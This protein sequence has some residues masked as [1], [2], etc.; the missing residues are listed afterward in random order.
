MVSPNAHCLHKGQ[1]AFKKVN[2]LC[3]CS[4]VAQLH[5][6]ALTLNYI[7][8]Q[9]QK[10][11]GSF[12]TYSHQMS[13]SLVGCAAAQLQAHQSI[14]ANIEWALSSTAF[15][16][17]VQLFMFANSINP[18]ST[19]EDTSSSSSSSSSGGSRNSDAFA[20]HFAMQDLLMGA[21]PN[22]D[23]PGGVR[24][25]SLHP[26]VGDKVGAESDQRVTVLSMHPVC[27]SS[28]SSSNG[29]GG[30]SLSSTGS[31]NSSSSSSSNTSLPSLDGF[32]LLSALT[33]TMYAPAAL[34]IRALILGTSEEVI[35][36][37]DFDVLPGK[38]ELR[39]D[40]NNSQVEMRFYISP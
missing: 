10:H 39:Y 33:L 24:F 20:F 17:C 38:Q 14:N 25:D 13:T 32:S 9:V 8:L 29:V 35:V 18:P 2:V 26:A 40:S 3:L 36:D 6:F 12:A 30:T 1:F 16:G 22:G 19:P 5:Q 23:Q 34:G 21:L 4:Y 28:F 11:P 15:R 37:V 7:A 27:L 31:G